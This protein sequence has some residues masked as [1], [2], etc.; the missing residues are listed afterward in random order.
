MIPAVARRAGFGVVLAVASF[1]AASAHAEPSRD[2]PALWAAARDADAPHA[3]VATP[4]DVPQTP[5]ESAP[6]SASGAEAR[7]AAARIDANKS[8][9]IPALE[10]LGFEVLLNQFDRHVLGTD[11]ASNISTIRRN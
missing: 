1:G 11:F 9:A 7:S 2:L 10:I 6:H 8:Y 5:A 3:A 4:V